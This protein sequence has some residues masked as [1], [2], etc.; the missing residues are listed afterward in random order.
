MGLTVSQ[1]VNTA[2]GT[3]TSK[4]LSAWGVVSGWCGLSSGVGV[5]A[6]G[7]RFGW[8]GVGSILVVTGGIVGVVNAVPDTLAGETCNR[9]KNDGA[10]QF[11]LA[12]AG[13]KM[14][15]VAK[16]K[17]LTEV[18]VPNGALVTVNTLP[19]QTVNIHLDGTWHVT[20][21]TCVNSPVL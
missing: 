6:D 13:L 17:T 16:Q 1:C 11:L 7:F 15:C 4:T 12:S 9:N 18:A 14:H 8:V 3:T 20:T 10:L 19:V 2:G 5:T 21:K